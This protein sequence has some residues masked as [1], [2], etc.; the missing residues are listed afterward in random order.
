MTC[1]SPP[2]ESE[3]F[4]MG[5]HTK[6]MP[7]VPGKSVY[8]A[9]RMLIRPKPKQR[10]R[11]NSKFVYTPAETRLYER[12]LKQEFIAFERSTRSVRPSD[13]LWVG[14]DIYFQFATKKKERWGKPHLFRPDIDNLEKAVLDAANGILYKDDCL[15]AYKYS[16]KEWAETDCVSIYIRYGEKS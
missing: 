13:P 10:P 14:V 3:S 1:L 12:M 11:M 6:A 15:V 16:C 9:F 8:T 4:W 2:T 7:E 5:N